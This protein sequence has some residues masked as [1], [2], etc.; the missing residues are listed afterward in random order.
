M[1]DRQQAL[2]LVFVQFVLFA[3]LAAALTLLPAGRPEWALWLGTALVALGLLV[4]AAALLT[5]FMINRSLVNVSPEP[6]QGAQL[7]ER[8][9]YAFIRHPIYTGVMYILV[10][11][12]I[13][14]VPDGF[15][16]EFCVDQVKK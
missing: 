2:F 1:T 14:S 7:V 3:L 12:L 8:G 5:Y 6:D 4:G 13:A 10:T 9:I 16:R 11:L 15:C